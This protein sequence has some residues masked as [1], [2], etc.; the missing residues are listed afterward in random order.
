MKTAALALGLLLVACSGRTRA[1]C[2][3]IEQEIRDGAI[4]R[5]YDG[6]GDGAPD[7][8]G[9]CGSVNESIKKDFSAICADLVECRN[10]Q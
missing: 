6:D 7:A 1:D 5:G 4:K 2:D 8:K 9:V 3:S 10:E